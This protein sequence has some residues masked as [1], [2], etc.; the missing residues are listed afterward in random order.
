MKTVRLLLVAASLAML[1]ASL[2][3]A[4]T[5]TPRI[6]HREDRQQGRIVQGIRSGELTRHEALRLEAG[7]RHVDRMEYRA[8]CDGRV[9]MRERARIA[10][11]Q[12]RQSREIFRFKHNGRV[13]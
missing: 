5:Y 9:T 3:N 10:R 7:Q 12:N 8:K 13:S 4:G 1:T 2:A 11:A 6:D